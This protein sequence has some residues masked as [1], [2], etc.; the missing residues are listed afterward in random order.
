MSQNSKLQA[1]SAYERLRNEIL[2]GELMPGERLRASELT[3]RY[4]LGLTPLREALVRLTSEGLVTSENHRGARVTGVSLTE[5]HDMMGVRQEIEELCLIKALK[6]GDAEWE[7]DIL[8]SFHVLST[9]QIPTK[10]GDFETSSK[11]EVHHR[12]FHHA[13]VVAC[14]SDWLMRFW[15]VLVDHTERY[16]K[17]R[18]LRL[19]MPQAAVR[20]VKEEHR[21]LMEAALSR[22]V[23]LITELMRDHLGET[24]KAVAALFEADP[25]LLK[26]IYK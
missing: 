26:G 5:F 10:D 6:Q 16:R 4:T 20:D 23:G 1:I 14:G 19:S 3:D 8:R 9:A 13:L 7:G 22:D 24:D 15:N 12:R 2:Y 21:L 18:M 11:W 17:L 25:N